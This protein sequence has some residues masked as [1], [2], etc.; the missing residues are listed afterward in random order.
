MYSPTIN[1][2]SAFFVNLLQE[3]DYAFGMCS[4]IDSLYSKVAS[5]LS[6]KLLSSSMKT[7]GRDL[8][9]VTPFTV[10]IIQGP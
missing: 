1:T 6:L 4:F 3:G 9:H 5:A 10:L 2:V 8:L 7:I